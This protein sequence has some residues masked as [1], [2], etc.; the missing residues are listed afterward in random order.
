M[1]DYGGH[2]FDFSSSLGAINCVRKPGTVCVWVVADQ[3]VDGDESGSSFRQCL[4]FKESGWKLHDTMIYLKDGFPFP[5][6]TRYQPVFEFM[7][8]FVCER[9]PI[10][11]PIKRKTVYGAITELEHERQKDGTISATKTRYQLEEGNVGNVWL[12]G[13]G[14]N[15]TSREPIAH[16]HPCAFPYQMAIDHIYSWTRTDALIYDPFMGSG[17]T[18]RAAKDLGRKAIGIEIEEKYCEIAAKR[19]SQKVLQF[20]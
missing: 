13:T 18:L 2:E 4:E 6:A 3:T 5:E 1:R 8:V 14:F 9:L 11:S 17:T 20:P 15:K 12:Y 16:E 10:F 7:F 19:L